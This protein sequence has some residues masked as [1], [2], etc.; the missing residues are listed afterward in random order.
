MHYNAVCNGYMW[1]FWVKYRFIERYNLQQNPEESES[2]VTQNGKLIRLM[3]DTGCDIRAWFREACHVSDVYNHTVS[4]KL[5]WATP[6]EVRDGCTPDI[7][8]FT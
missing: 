5:G 7:K 6:I 3:I 4:E 2:M 1:K 8:L